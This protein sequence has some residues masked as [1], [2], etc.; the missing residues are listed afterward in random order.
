MKVKNS[1]VYVLV[2]LSGF[3][4]YMTISNFVLWLMVC[5]GLSMFGSFTLVVLDHLE[6][7][8]GVVD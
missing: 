5:L 8:G 6:S 2:F 4:L 7:M 1:F 3:L